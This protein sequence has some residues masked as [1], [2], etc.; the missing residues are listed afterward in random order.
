MRTESVSPGDTFVPPTATATLEINGRY[1]ETDVKGYLLDVSD[2]DSDVTIQMANDD[3]LVLTDD[4]WILIDFL[5]RFYRE[6]QIAPELPVLSRCLCRDQKDC[7]WNRK[8]IHQLFPMG[9]KAA[10]RYA[11]LPEPFGRS[12]V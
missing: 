1:I 3:G 2:W 5:H 9:A 4:H 11:G 6:Y 7:R 12:C 8:F 10:C